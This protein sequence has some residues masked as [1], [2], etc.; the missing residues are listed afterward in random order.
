M[1]GGIQF[2]LVAL[3]T[4]CASYIQ[5]VTGFGFGI[6]AMIFLPKILLYTEASLLSSMLSTVTSLV[7][8]VLAFR[9]ISWKNLI[10]PVMGCL[11][12]TFFAVSFIKMQKDDTLTLLLGIALL[13][14]SLYFFF[15]SDKIKI[16]PT[17]YTGLFVGVLSGILDGMFAIGG[18]PV[19]IY[20][21]QSE[22]DSDSY[23]ATLSTYFVFLGVVSSGSKCISGFG[24]VTVWI[25]LAVALIALA[26]GA[27]VGK[28]TR[29][30]IKPSLIKNAYTALWSFPEYRI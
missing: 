7:V 24:T 23:M 3:V 14:L 28:L 22:K 21:M 29:E 4:L 16:K 26:V 27:F 2:I 10:F 12:S 25:S 5:S 15:F 13:L 17:W 20:Y 19:V 8:M 6:F 1:E 11:A 30:R 9:K 18:P